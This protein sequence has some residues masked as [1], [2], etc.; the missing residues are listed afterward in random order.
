MRFGVGIYT[1][2]G[3]PLQTVMEQARLAE[4]LGYDS[5]W[6]LDSQLVG[7]EVYAT[8]ACCAMATERIEIC[9]GVTQ[10]YTRHATVTACGHATINELAPG[11]V[12]L[13]IGRGDSAVLGIGGK[14]PSFKEFGQYVDQ[15][16]RLLR[17]EVIELNGKPAQLTFLDKDLPPV[18]TYVAVGGPRALEFGPALADRIIIHA[19]AGEIMI[20]RSMEH[21]R[22]GAQKAGKDLSKMEVVWWVHTSIDDDWSKVKEHYR[23]KMGGLR[24]KRPVS[25]EELGVHLD[26]ETVEK[27]KNAYSFLDHATPGAAHGVWADVFPDAVWK[28][29]ALLG[30]EAECFETV[31]KGLEANPEINHFVINPPVAGFGITIEGIIERFARGVM[32]RLKA[33]K[34]IAA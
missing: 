31:R 24:H 20:S 2:H 9:S 7:R 27:I 5:L 1:G 16:D 13:G 11:R 30:T 21:L 28:Q 10:P 34:V 22:T 14:L 8:M 33:E 29:Y 6:L 19:G 3:E 26:A 15:V 18:K 12:A 17:G 23:P 25:L 4:R 32:E